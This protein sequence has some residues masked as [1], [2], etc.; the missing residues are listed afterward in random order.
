M[1]FQM[2]LLLYDEA[3]AAF[4]GIGRLE[5]R[6][7]TDCGHNGNKVPASSDAARKWTI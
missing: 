3:T 5:R 7:G 4:C 2:V 1:S 6:E